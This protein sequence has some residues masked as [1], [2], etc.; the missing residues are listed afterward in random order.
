MPET[1]ILTAQPGDV[2]LVHV[3]SENTEEQ[4]AA[5]GKKIKE[6]LPECTILVLPKSVQVSTFPMRYPEHKEGVIVGHVVQ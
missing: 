2:V 5:H 1:Y 3:D 6:A 4:M